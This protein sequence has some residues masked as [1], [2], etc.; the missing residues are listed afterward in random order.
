M[1][2]NVRKVKVQLGLKVNAWLDLRHY[3][4]EEWF[5]L[6]IVRQMECS[7][8][9]RPNFMPD[10]SLP[11][12]VKFAMDKVLKPRN[13]YSGWER[14]TSSKEQILCAANDTVACL[15]VFVR[16]NSVPWR[17]WKAS[18][19]PAVGTHN[20]RTNLFW[21]THFLNFGDVNGPF[22]SGISCFTVLANERF[23]GVSQEFKWSAEPS[24]NSGHNYYEYAECHTRREWSNNELQ[25]ILCVCLVLLNK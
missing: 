4:A 15:D 5:F 16:N 17:C 11:S 21:P 8:R 24:E 9:P 14:D 3:S 1:T 13:K 10:F 25:D 22:W 7:G 23:L 6:E 20:Y 19:P 2:D 18:K 12:L